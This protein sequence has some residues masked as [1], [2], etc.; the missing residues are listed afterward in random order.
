MIGSHFTIAHHR[1]PKTA[2][3]QQYRDWQ[4]EDWYGVPGKKISVRWPA[5]KY[6]NADQG[7]LG[8]FI[9]LFA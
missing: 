4:A 3:C 6:S 9:I 8:L 2:N 5:K 1:S 7:I